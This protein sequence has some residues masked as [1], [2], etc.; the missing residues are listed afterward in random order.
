MLFRSLQQASH[1]LAEAIYKDAQAQQ[2]AEAPNGNAAAGGGD[3][4]A[5]DA[6]Y[7]V[8]EDDKK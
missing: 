2:Q 6:D 3:D 8:V 5:V 4:G 1:K 7:E